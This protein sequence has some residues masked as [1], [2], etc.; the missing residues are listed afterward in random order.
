MS[1]ISRKYRTKPIAQWIAGVFFSKAFSYGRDW[2]GG[3]RE[4]EFTLGRFVWRCAVLEN[5]ER[6]DFHWSKTV[7]LACWCAA[8]DGWLKTRISIELN[9]WKRNFYGAIRRVDCWCE[10]GIGGRR[11]VGAGG[12]KPL[13]RNKK[14]HIKIDDF[15]LKYDDY[16]ERTAVGGRSMISINQYLWLTNEITVRYWNP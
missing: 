14:K 13:D 11:P 4:A 5:N 8:G 7:Y 9:W 10:V 6:A 16:L 3:S 1:L 2:G 15:M 12:R